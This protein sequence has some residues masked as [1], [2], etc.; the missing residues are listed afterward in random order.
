[1]RCL[2][3]REDGSFEPLHLPI[4][5]EYSAIKEM[6]KATKSEWGWLYPIKKTKGLWVLVDETCTATMSDEEICKH[7]NP[8][9]ESLLGVNIVCGDIAVCRVNME[10]AEKNRDEYANSVF[11][12]MTFEDALF[13]GGIICESNKKAV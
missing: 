1:M 11:E 10:E 4:D 8:I 13:L 6:E 12:E 5:E 3:I 7:R 2:I 9:A